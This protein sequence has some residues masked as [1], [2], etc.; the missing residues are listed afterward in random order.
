[1]FSIWSGKLW[2][3][4]SYL[5]RVKIYT[6]RITLLHLV[7][8]I[9]YVYFT[10]NLTVFTP[11]WEFITNHCFPISIQSKLIC[12][13]IEGQ[14]P[15]DTMDIVCQNNSLFTVQYLFCGL[16]CWWSSMGS[17]TIFIVPYIH[18]LPLLLQMCHSPLD[19]TQSKGDRH[20]PNSFISKTESTHSHIIHT[21]HLYTHNIIVHVLTHRSLLHTMMTLAMSATLLSITFTC[22]NTLGYFAYFTINYEDTWQDRD[23]HTLAIVSRLYAQTTPPLKLPS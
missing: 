13:L 9:F 4:K 12:A 3:V 16:D 15:I 22:A 2:L 5:A 23:K 19:I 17:C 6:T 8:L 20:C 7:C 21:M 10:A 14:K 11:W 18:L 1:M